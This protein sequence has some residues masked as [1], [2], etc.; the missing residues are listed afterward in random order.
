[1]SENWS[2]SLVSQSY[3][4]QKSISAKSPVAQL[5]FNISANQDFEPL[6]VLQ[7]DYQ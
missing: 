3:F 1:M 2:S 7:S 5:A 4:R 6:L